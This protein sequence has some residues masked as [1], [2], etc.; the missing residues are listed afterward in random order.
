LCRQFCLQAKPYRKVQLAQMIRAAL[1]ADA[2]T[3][4]DSRPNA[5]PPR[6]TSSEPAP[7]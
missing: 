5:V 6:K 2:N 3:Q 1:S 4:A 7:V